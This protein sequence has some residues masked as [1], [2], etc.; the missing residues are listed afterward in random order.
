MSQFRVEVLYEGRV[1][2]VYPQRQDSGTSLQDVCTRIGM[3][4]MA[5][6]ISEIVVYRDGEEYR[7][8]AVTAAREESA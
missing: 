6:T 4:A 2:Q 8:V 1:V 5:D 7:R 3:M